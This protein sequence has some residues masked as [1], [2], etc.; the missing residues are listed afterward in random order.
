MLIARLLLTNRH[1]TRPK[2]ARSMLCIVACVLAEPVS[3]NLGYGGRE[4]G[5][6]K[7]GSE[8]RELNCLSSMVVLPSFLHLF[9]FNPI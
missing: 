6:L 7:E 5:K 3:M 1:Y 4:G 8:G 9:I 2:G